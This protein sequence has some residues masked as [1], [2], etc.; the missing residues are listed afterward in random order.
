KN[1]NYQDLRSGRLQALW[2]VTDAFDVRAMAIVHR[3]ESKLGLGYENPDHTVPVQIDPARVLVPKKF[4]YD[5]FSLNLGYDFGGA[6]LISA[7]TYVDHHHQYPFS[8][9]GGDQTIYGGTL[10]GTDARYTTANQFSQEVRLA[11]S[12]DGPWTWT[13]GGFYRQLNTQLF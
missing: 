9:I 8:Y 3:N 2:K 10:A 7:S 1:G 12:G 5:L 13:V 11:S 4:D 6:Q